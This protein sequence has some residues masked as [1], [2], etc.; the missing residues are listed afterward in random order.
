[1]AKQTFT[2]V[3]E[4]LRAAFPDAEI[5]QIRVS[6]TGGYSGEPRHTAA[7]VQLKFFHDDLAHPDDLPASSASSAS[8][9]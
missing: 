6:D 5:N 8:G 7:D 3:L 9:S 4:R 1:M 2:Q